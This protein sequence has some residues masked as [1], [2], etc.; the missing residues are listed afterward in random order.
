LIKKKH[1]VC[2][3]RFF[4][5]LQVDY[6]K[7]QVVAVLVPPPLVEVVALSWQINLASPFVEWLII[8]TWAGLVT[9]VPLEEV[10]VVVQVQV[11][12]FLQDANEKID[13]T[14]TNKNIFF[15]II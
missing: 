2:T 1:L 3:K 7:V 8:V 6:F 4:F 9:A 10:E 5:N 14:A 13:A 11:L 12:S 15:M